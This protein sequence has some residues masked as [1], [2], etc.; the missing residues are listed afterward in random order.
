[1]REMSVA[2]GHS[3]T[4]APTGWASSQAAIALASSNDASSPF[5][6][7]LPAI[8]LRGDVKASSNKTSG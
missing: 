1:M 7:Q 8:R 2:G 3:A 5:I 4:R 6:F